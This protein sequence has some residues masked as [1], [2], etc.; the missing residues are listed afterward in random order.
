MREGGGDASGVVQFRDD[1]HFLELKH[2]PAGRRA[3]VLFEAFVAHMIERVWLNLPVI[4]ID[5]SGFVDNDAITRS[6]IEVRIHLQDIAEVALEGLQEI[7]LDQLHRFL[8]SFFMKKE[9]TLVQ[10]LLHCRIEP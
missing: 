9:H 4:V 6:E 2:A 8:P 7:P 1:H 5:A 10:E 3:K